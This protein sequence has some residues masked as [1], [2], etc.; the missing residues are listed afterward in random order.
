MTIEGELDDISGVGQTLAA[1]DLCRNIPPA[2]RHICSKVW[3]TTA[4]STAANGASSFTR[5]G[6]EFVRKVN[7]KEICL[8]LHRHGR[9]W[10]DHPRVYR[11]RTELPRANSWI[12]VPSTRMTE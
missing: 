11:C 6:A 8:T 2:K 5:R 9:A 1:H 3:A 12:L 10:H 7:Y 4:S